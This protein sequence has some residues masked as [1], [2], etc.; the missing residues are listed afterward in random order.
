MSHLENNEMLLNAAGGKKSISKRMFYAVVVILSFALGT[1]VGK[2]FTE[3]QN[4]VG[5]LMIK[6]TM[7]TGVSDLRLPASTAAAAAAAGEVDQRI[8]DLLEK[9][10]QEVLDLCKQIKT[11]EVH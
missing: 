8:V 6:H 5:S 1:F 4:K 2:T 9:Q 7:P 10:R 11:P 3:N